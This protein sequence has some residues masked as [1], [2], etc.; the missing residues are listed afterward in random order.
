MR[1]WVFLYLFGTDTLRARVRSHIH[2][3]EVQYP[4]QGHVTTQHL[5]KKILDDHDDVIMMTSSLKKKSKIQST[6]IGLKFGRGMFSTMPNTMVVFILR[7][8]DV[9]K[10]VV[11]SSSKGSPLKK[12]KNSKCSNRFFFQFQIYQRL[13][14]FNTSTHIEHDTRLHGT[15]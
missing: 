11:T 2:L 14:L 4:I 10:V 13:N 3:P 6:P 1:D 5:S 8:N 7:E 9:I 15:S 12:V